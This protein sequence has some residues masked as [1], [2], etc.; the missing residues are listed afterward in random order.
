M[1]GLRTLLL[2]GNSLNGTLPAAWGALDGLTTL[3]LAQNALR[4]P[5]PAQ[6]SSLT[7]LASLDASSNYLSGPLPDAW[8]SLDSLQELRLANNNLGGAVPVSWSEL[9]SLTLLDLSSNL[10]VCGGQPPWRSG[11]Q[12]RT[13]ATNIEQ[14]CIMVQTSGTVA[15]AVLGVSLSLTVASLAATAALLVYVRRQRQ[16]LALL[17]RERSASFTSFQLNPSFSVGGSGPSAIAVADP[18]AATDGKLA[19]LHTFAATAA[20]GVQ[21]RQHPKLAKAL[22]IIPTWADEHSGYIQVPLATPGP[23]PARHGVP[24]GAEEHR[25]PSPTPGMPSPERHQWQVAAAAADRGVDLHA[26]RTQQR[27]LFRSRSDIPSVQP[28]SGDEAAGQQGQLEQWSSQEEG[29]DM[30]RAHSRVALLRPGD[31]D[32]SSMV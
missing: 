11:A 7:S 17:Q 14:S 25:S 2:G 4:G 21:S 22:S 13:D 1:S 9:P 30:L 3:N 16:Q 27:S 23:A 6:W 31:R 15:G 26:R 5:L 24:G 8:R 18:A 20:A 28:S 19:T 29:V 32:G 10:G 12:V